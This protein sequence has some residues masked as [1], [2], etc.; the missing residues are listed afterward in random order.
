MTRELLVRASLAVPV[1]VLLPLGLPGVQRSRAWRMLLATAVVSLA[2][3]GSWD[4][5]KAWAVVGC[6]VAGAAV[7]VGRPGRPWGSLCAATV[8]TLATAL[9]IDAAGVRSGLAAVADDW[10]VAVVALGALACVFVGGVVISVVLHPFAQR[11][12]D[13]SDVAGME[14]AGRIIGW[15]ERALL[16]GLVLLGAPDAA[17]LVIAG[18]SIARF[19]SFKREQFAEYYLIGSLLSLTIALG[20][21]VAVRAIVGL[22]PV[23]P[24]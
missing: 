13:R 2:L 8:A 4:E 1:A 6:A 16:F 11:V 15:V 21:A 18:K 5:W 22:D 20:A 9:L 17:A 24:L 10:R 12:G 7:P 14:N 3:A 23:A 19:P